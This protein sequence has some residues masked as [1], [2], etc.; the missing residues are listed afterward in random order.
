MEDNKQEDGTDIDEAEDKYLDVTRC[1]PTSLPDEEV[2][3]QQDSIKLTKNTKGYN[4]EV[5][6]YGDDV[7]DKVIKLEE[8]MMEKYGKD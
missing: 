6:C 4:W 2:H 8:K 5:K 1:I 7:F 3:E